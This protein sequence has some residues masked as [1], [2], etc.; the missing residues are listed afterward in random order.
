MATF[1]D[2]AS[3][4]HA[5]ALE[6]NS[7]VIDAFGQE[8]VVTRPGIE[9]ATATTR[10]VK[11]RPYPIHNR[12]DFAKY[13]L[14]GIVNVADDAPVVFFAKVGADIKPGDTLSYTYA[15]VTHTYRIMHCGPP[16]DVTGS[17][18]RLDCVG[19]REH[20]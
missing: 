15:G 2:L 8:Y 10:T 9:S 19:K 16:Y 4:I 7:G 13:N 1:T 20:A 14:E 11:L 17:V 6:L 18:T 3:R 5:K 12:D